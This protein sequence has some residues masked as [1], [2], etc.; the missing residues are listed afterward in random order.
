MKHW[1]IRR[2]GI[3]L[4]LAFG[5]G[6]ACGEVLLV[7]EAVSVPAYSTVTVR[8]L[9]TNKSVETIRW[10]VAGKLR[11]RLHSGSSAAE[12][13]VLRAAVTEAE[14]EV[15]SGGFAQF[16]YRFE[17]QPETHGPVVLEVI[18]PVAGERVPPAMFAVQEDR[19]TLS[20]VK[21][22]AGRAVDELGTVTHETALRRSTRLFPGIS[23]YEPVYF[24]IGVNSGLN[25]KFQFSLKYQPIDLWPAY[26]SFTQTSLWD[27]ESESAPFRDTA[28]RPRIFYLNESLWV[29]PDRRSWF[30]VESGIGHESNGR[31]GPSSRSINIAYVRP[32]YDWV[33]M[34]GLRFHVSPMIY[35]YIEKE[36]NPDIPRY[37]GY[38]DLLLGVEKNGWRLNTT[39]RKGTAGSRGSIQVD[40]VL[41]L[42]ASDP[43]F[44]RIG[45]RGLNGYW[46]F[47]Y[48]NGWGET[49]LDYNLKLEAQ[50]RTGIMLVP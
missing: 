48:F 20:A 40:A 27:L 12:D 47:Q 49:I 9:V 34:N 7:P 3:A 37:R 28:Y 17:L 14:R 44:N 50:F 26:L 13:V 2:F 38:V 25:A 43:V 11:A 19:D 4:A 30:G 33:A 16:S 31:A 36:D 32:T 21:A 22:D 1:A 24:G 46:F 45:A 10:R 35:G 8:L 41:P 18:E 6:A 39:L 15:V 42:R 5:L 23:R 29:A